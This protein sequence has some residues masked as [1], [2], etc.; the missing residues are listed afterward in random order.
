M[1]LGAEVVVGVVEEFVAVLEGVVVDP[2]GAFKGEVETKFFDDL[3]VRGFEGGFAILDLAAG[4]GPEDEDPP[5]ALGDGESD[6]EDLT[7]RVEEED[8]GCLAFTHRVRVLVPL[9]PP[10]RVRTARRGPRIAVR[11]R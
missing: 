9:T 2:E 4:C 8:S 7:L 3:A 1:A 10:Q 6:E 11:S 5:V